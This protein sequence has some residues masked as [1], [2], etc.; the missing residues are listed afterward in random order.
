M[1]HEEA[2]RERIRFRGS[3]QRP[4][5]PL[6][7]WPGRFVRDFHDASSPLARYHD[8]EL[9]VTRRVIISVDVTPSV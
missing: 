3:L 7:V 4:S 8:D 2:D 1:Q 6:Y 5:I 9:A